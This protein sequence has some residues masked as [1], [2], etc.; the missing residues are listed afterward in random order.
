M[1]GEVFGLPVSAAGPTTLLTLVVLFILT[2]RLVPRSTLQDM[3]EERDTWRAAHAKS[4]AAREA[5][6]Q[7]VDELLETARLGNQMLASLPR[8][9]PREEVAPDDRVDQASRPAR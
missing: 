9:Q 7:L 1:G 6:R 2:G 8:P 4:E 3:R 5:E